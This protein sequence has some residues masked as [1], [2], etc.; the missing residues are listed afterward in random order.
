MGKKILIIDEAG[1]SRVCSVILESSGHEVEDIDY[2]DNLSSN[3]DN[4]E[5]GLVVTSYPYGAFIFEE[6]KKKKIPAIILLDHINNNLFAVLKELDNSY[7]MIKPLDYEKFRLL[8]NQIMSGQI[9]QQG[10]Y[11]I[12]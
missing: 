10:G 5:I 8:V 7:C 1:F 2:I 11:S 6:I 4:N 3:K 9:I 12:V